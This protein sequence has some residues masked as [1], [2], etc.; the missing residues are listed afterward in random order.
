MEV[1]GGLEG[2]L[3]GWKGIL[4]SETIQSL[5]SPLYVDFSTSA[6]IQYCICIAW[7]CML[8]VQMEVCTGRSGN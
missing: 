3:Q 1:I 2:H 5:A 8:T 7:R 6:N 4:I